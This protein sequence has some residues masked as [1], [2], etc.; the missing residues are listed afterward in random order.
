MRTFGCLLAEGRHNHSIRARPADMDIDPISSRSPA[1]CMVAPHFPFVLALWL[2]LGTS[3]LEMAIRVAIWQLT[4]RPLEFGIHIVWMAP[5]MNL[6]WFSL[7]AI[8]VALT[9]RL[10]PRRIGYG[11]VVGVL[12]FPALLS[13][14]WLYAQVHWMAMAVL[15][16]GLAVQSGVLASRRARALMPFSRRAALTTVVL[17]ATLILTVLGTN[18]WREWSA[19]RALPSRTGSSNVLLLVLDTVRSF[20]MSAYGYARTTT[21]TLERLANEGV[22]FE[23][24]FATSGWTLPSH[25]S[26]FTGR[27]AH[28]IRTGPGFPLPDGVPTLAEALTAAGYATGGF[29]ANLNYTSWEHGVGRG[30]IRYEDYPVTPLTLLTS[31]SLGRRLFAAQSV[32]NLVE[33]Y[34]DEDRKSA[35]TV[36]QDFLAWL[37]GLGGKPFFGFLNYFDAHHPYL[38]P[39]PFDTLFGPALPPAYRPYLPEFDQFSSQ[40]IALASNSYHGA[41]AYIDR[42]IDNLIE[43]LR[44]RDLLDNTLIIITSD[45]GEHFGDHDLLGHGNSFYRQLLQVPLIMRFPR[46]IPGASIISAPVSLRDL[47][48]TILDI[49][50]I[51]DDY[52]IP[53]TSLIPIVGDS[54]ASVSEVVSGRALTLAPEVQ[55]LISDGMHYIRKVDGGEELYHI[56]HDSLEQQSLVASRDS[57]SALSALRAKLDSI[58][59]VAPPAPR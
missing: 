5:L 57:H 35:A 51:P 33:Y 21:P 9:I 50:R 25:A 32:R 19:M 28:E 48:A 52:G 17:V 3:L 30:F 47:P 54:T 20:S 1:T 8:P 4:I 43:E 6:I 7:V 27:Y 26:M 46:R 53:G 37:D 38:P 39:A 13:L 15:A 24:A 34:D 44:Q 59:T 56:E 23:R 11:V 40:E 55:S 36:Q 49:T 10:W 12:S 45:H 58:E 16:L 42:Q 41:I 29:V 18:R 31:T 22:R 14:L 2:A